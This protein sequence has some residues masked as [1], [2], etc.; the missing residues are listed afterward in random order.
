MGEGV[1]PVYVDNEGRSVVRNGDGTVGDGN[2]EGI[3]AS[4]LLIGIIFDETCLAVEE[5]QIGDTG[6]E[7]A[8]TAGVA[9]ES[10]LKVDV[11]VGFPEA[12]LPGGQQSLDVVLAR[13]AV[14]PDMDSDVVRWFC[15]RL[16][17]GD[18][19]EDTAAQ[20]EGGETAA[21][22]GS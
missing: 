21:G 19:E 17:C 6:K 20:R 18:C 22:N 13:M 3:V 12:I 9:V 15:L 1:G 16:K 11:G 14:P 8:D 7:T 4:P 2:S 5:S 10:V